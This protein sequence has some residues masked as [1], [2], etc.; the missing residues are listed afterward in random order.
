M[1]AYTARRIAMA[2]DPSRQRSCTRPQP[3]DAGPALRLLACCVAGLLVAGCS[4]LL[5]I[6]KLEPGNDAGTDPPPDADNGPSDTTPP[7]ILGITPAPDSVDV[8]PDAV[9]TVTFDEPVNPDALAASIEVRGPDDSTVRVAVDIQG[10]VATFDPEIDLALLGTHTA[11]VNTSV[12]DLAGNALPLAQTWKFTVRDGA[13]GASDLIEN[14]NANR[15]FRQQI[16]MDDAGNAIAVW[17]QNTTVWTNRYD[18]AK[19]WG[20]SV[21]LEPDLGGDARDARVGMDAQGNA[22]AIWT[23]VRAGRIEIMTRRYDAMIGDWGGVAPLGILGAGDAREPQLAMSPSGEAVAV[24]TQP[25]AGTTR[26][27]LW[28]SSYRADGGGWTM[29]RLIENDDTDSVIAP[30]VAISPVG[31]AMAVW[32][33]DNGMRTHVWANFNVN[34]TSWLVPEQLEPFETGSSAQPHVAMDYAGNAVAVWQA[35]SDVKASRYADSGWTVPEVI[36]NNTEGPPFVAVDPR[37]NAVAAARHAVISGRPGRMVAAH[38]GATAGAWDKQ[39]I[40]GVIDINAAASPPVV[41]LDP[42]GNALAVWDFHDADPIMLV[43]A[44]YRPGIGWTPDAEIETP[45]SG[46]DPQIAINR[47]GK[48]W[49]TWGSRNIDDFR[50]DINATPFR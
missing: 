9:L 45:R 30:R 49:L 46:Q 24:W 1:P 18:V 50:R 43:A 38:H 40:I 42:L 2:P 23:Q 7:R 29:P 4:Q 33:Q 12:T 32:T 8:E 10:N 11:V 39:V 15:S 27:S 35:G 20:T 25:D 26:T 44:R 16:A 28:S 13:W 14:N 17:D 3:R 22:L 6:E 34:G 21:L 37:G 41:A 19:G 36:M 5:G 31:S 48:A 47:Q